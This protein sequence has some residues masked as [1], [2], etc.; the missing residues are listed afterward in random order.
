MIRIL[1]LSLLSDRELYGYEINRILRKKY[2]RFTRVS[3]SS[4]YYTLDRLEK[5]GLITKREEKVGN[6]PARHIYRITPEG[7]AELQKR[8][9]EKIRK[10][11]MKINIFDPFN[12]PFSLMGKLPE[13]ALELLKM[14]LNV[15]RERLEEVEKHHLIL[16]ELKK[17]KDVPELDAFALTLIRRGILHLKAEKKWLE[18]TIGLLRRKENQKKEENQSENSGLNQDKEENQKEDNQ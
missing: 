10:E 14:R 7:R 4:I 12:M 15:V 17:K 16:T 13:S 9:P 2:M 1:L 8:L 3:F 11:G 18:E 6:R 5:D